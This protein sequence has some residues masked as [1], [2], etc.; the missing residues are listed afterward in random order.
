MCPSAR[1][2]HSRVASKHHPSCFPVK[3]HSDSSVA[4]KSHLPCGYRYR[5]TMG[6]RWFC[7]KVFLSHFN[8]AHW[9]PTIKRFFLV[10]LIPPSSLTKRKYFHLRSPICKLHATW[11]STACNEAAALIKSES[12]APRD[13]QTPNI[14][15]QASTYWVLSA[16]QNPQGNQS[17]VYY[18][19][20]C[21]PDLQCIQKGQ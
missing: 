9:S 14:W 8:G 1:R 15:N 2:V 13:Q 11:P 19:L 6:K 12:R 20:W 10:H 5:K 18:P 7:S 3:T 16:M 4:P 17:H 21:R